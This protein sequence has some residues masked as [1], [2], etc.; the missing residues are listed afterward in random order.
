MLSAASTKLVES[1]EFSSE[2]GY[3]CVRLN[4][5]DKTCLN[6]A[7]DAG[8]TIETDYADWKTG[9][10]RIIRRWPMVRSLEF[11][12]LLKEKPRLKLKG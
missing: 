1:V 4:F 12:D 8:F 6:F 11:R 2:P 7:I 10:Q 5:K 3:H 9:N